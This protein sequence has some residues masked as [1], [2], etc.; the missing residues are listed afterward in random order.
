MN[1]KY[2]EQLARLA[3][4]MSTS[5]IVESNENHH[6]EQQNISICM[7]GIE[8]RKNRALTVY[9]GEGNDIQQAA[10]NLLYKLPGNILVKNATNKLNRQEFAIINISEDLKNDKEQNRILSIV[11]RLA[12]LKPSLLSTNEAIS[13]LVQLVNDAYKALEKDQ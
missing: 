12:A 7:Q 2:F 10:F 1:S 4:S 9:I 8:F 13:C 6:S 11:E 3:A 5:L